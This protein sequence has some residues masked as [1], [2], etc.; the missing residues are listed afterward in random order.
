MIISEIRYDQVIER[1][2]FDAEHYQPDFLE[3]EKILKRV[4]CIY[5]KDVAVFSKLRRNPENEPDKEIGYIDISNV[6][7]F[8][9][10]TT[11]QRLKGYQ[12]PSRARKVVRE[13]DI[14]LSTVRPNRNAVAIIPGELDNEICSTGFSVI[15]AKKINPWFLFAFLKTKYAINQLVRLTMASMYP[16]VSEED[17]STLLIPCMPDAF[18]EKIAAMIMKAF[19]EKRE[20]I[21]QL[22]D[23]EQA[24]LRNLRLP[25]PSLEFKN[26]YEI[27]FDELE[28]RID[29]E[30]YQPKFIQII[31]S[32]KSN[33]YFNTVTIND[34]YEEIK[35]GTSENLDYVESGIPFLRLSELNEFFS[36]DLDNLKYIR[37][38]DAIRLKPYMVEENDIL[39]SRTG[40]VGCAVHIDSK[41]SGSIFGSYFIKVK[42]KK[43]FNPLYISIFLNSTYGKLQADRQRT[44]AV[45]TNLTIPAI[46]S[47]KIAI[48]SETFQK[49]L[50]ENYL[51]LL[52]KRNK[53]RTLFLTAIQEVEDF[54]EKGS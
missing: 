2:R 50:C 47:L 53:A 1:L 22:V 7:T 32:L 24:L 15:K 29:S 35:Y 46:L 20:A 19:K 51:T 49:E 13:N 38:I 42:I 45:Q 12:A 30:F 25:K 44:G 6:N 28:D 26:N 17:I 37:Q 3:Y 21:I 40:T 4:K 8:T 16:A 27:K 9:G 31:H 39:I 36:F 52:K 33:K 41:L 54:I 10:E 48:P 11:T 14:I 5:L 23:V 43:G 18:Q 34:I